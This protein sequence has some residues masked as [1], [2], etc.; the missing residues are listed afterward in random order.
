MNDDQLDRTLQSIGMKCF[1]KY[2]HEFCN[3]SL[4]SGDL[5]ELLMKEEGYTESG[6]RTRVSCARRIIQAGR[7]KDALIKISKSD[8]VEQPFADQARKIASIQNM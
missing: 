8:R 3:T 2:F 1:V 6:C 4:S 5:I 7:A